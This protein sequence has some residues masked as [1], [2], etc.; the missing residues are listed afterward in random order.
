MVIGI[1]T[2]LVKIRRI[3]RVHACYRERFARRILGPREYRDYQESKRPVLH[4]ARCFAVKEAAAKAL[5]AGFQ[6]GLSWRDIELR[7]VGR[8]APWLSLE[9]KAQSLSECRKVRQRHLSIADED[10]YVLAFVVLSG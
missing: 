3:A 8:G 7:R 10:G 2:D 5:G 6:D 1:G 9:G 4:L